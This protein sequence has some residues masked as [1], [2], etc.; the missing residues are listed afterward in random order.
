MAVHS[1][2]RGDK[3]PGADGALVVETRKILSTQTGPLM[4]AFVA[5]L[6][7]SLERLRLKV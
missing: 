3:E 2:E 7:A 1:L 6:S 4:H 5:P